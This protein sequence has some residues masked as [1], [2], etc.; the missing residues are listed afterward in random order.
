M[1]V[2]L[3]DTGDQRIQVNLLLGVNRLKHHTTVF[4]PHIND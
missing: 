2:F 3:G 1:R 4:S